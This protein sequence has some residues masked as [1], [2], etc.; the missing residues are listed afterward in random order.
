MVHRFNYRNPLGF[1][2]CFVLV[3]RGWEAGRGL[4][5]KCSFRAY[6]MRGR[7]THAHTSAEKQSGAPSSSHHHSH[8]ST[9]PPATLPASFLFAHI[10]TQPLHYVPSL[11]LLGL[12]SL[13]NDLFLP[14]SF[15]I[16][17][18]ITLFLLYHSSQSKSIHP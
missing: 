18:L 3:L 8:R 5:G 17:C 7:Y 9:G 12:M 6:N 15:F 14:T 11:V 13:V 10:L 2:C 16:P 4:R 1:L